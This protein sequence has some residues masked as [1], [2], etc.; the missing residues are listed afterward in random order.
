[1]F[2]ALAIWLIA[3]EQ[4]ERV[5]RSRSCH[6]KAEMS[7]VSQVSCRTCLHIKQTQLNALGHLAPAWPKHASKT[8]RLHYLAQ[9]STWVPGG[10]IAEI[11]CGGMRPA[12]QNPY[13]FLNQNLRFSLPYLRPEQKF[14][15]LFKTWPLTEYPVS[16]LPYI[17]SSL[18]Q[19]TNVSVM[20][21]CFY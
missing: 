7:A 21:I 4:D 15:T 19:E 3:T 5:P 1:M 11:L 16:G 20:I 6:F 17:I 18:V 9:T 12:S 14:E 8:P 2:G 13:P 10:V